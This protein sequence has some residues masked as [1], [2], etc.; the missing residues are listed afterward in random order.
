MQYLE[1]PLTATPQKFTVSLSGTDYQMSVIYRD[2]D[3]AGW[4][5]DIADNT[6]TAIVN[7][8]PLVTGANL[9]A[10]YPHLGF[11]GRL[12]VQGT[13]DPDAV[14]TYANLGTENLLLWVTE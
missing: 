8:I 10:Q 5:L 12:W 7:G 4:V 14:P 3:Q 1:I 2:A 6:G 11:K 13:I 9:L